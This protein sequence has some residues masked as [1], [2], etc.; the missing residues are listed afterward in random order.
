ML[1]DVFWSLPYLGMISK[2]EDFELYVTQTGSS[3]FSCSL[4]PATKSRKRDILGHVESKHFP[5]TFSYQCQYCEATLGT[6]TAHRHHVRI[7]HKDALTS[8]QEWFLSLVILTCQFIRCPRTGGLWEVCGQEWRSGVHVW[9]VLWV[10]SQN[11]ILRCD[12]RGV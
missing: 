10:L 3:C 2:P 11:Q 1:R 7:T 6:A 9:T 5:H 8:I 4:C 12:A